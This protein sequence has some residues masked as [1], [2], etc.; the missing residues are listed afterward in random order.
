MSSST[1]QNAIAPFRYPTIPTS[2]LPRFNTYYC[3]SVLPVHAKELICD[4]E[5][6]DRIFHVLRRRRIRQTFDW[7]EHGVW[8]CYDIELLWGAENCK[9]VARN[10]TGP[11]RDHLVP[12]PEGAD[13]ILGRLDV[14]PA[15]AALYT[16][17]TEGK[18]YKDIVLSAMNISVEKG[19]PL[20]LKLSME[21]YL[22]RT[23]PQIHRVVGLYKS[24][25]SVDI[26]LE[27][28]EVTVISK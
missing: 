3:T 17:Q 1:H 4:I 16:N 27:R 6:S 14:D 7:E 15:V 2:L 11:D 19:W 8:R 22:V 18:S 5:K 20:H 28:L 23:R 10:M 21:T 9:V 12:H 13:L 26:L 25:D 24:I